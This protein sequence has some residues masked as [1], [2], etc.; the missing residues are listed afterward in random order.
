MGRTVRTV[1]TVM[2]IGVV[3]AVAL[4]VL[5]LGSSTGLVFGGQTTLTGDATAKTP[6]YAQLGWLKNTSPWPLT[7]KSITV[8]ATNASKPTTVYIEPRHVG[9]LSVTPGKTPVW[10]TN[11]GAPPQD[12]VGG[13]LR[14]LAFGLTPTEGEVASFTSIT[15]TFSGPLGFTFHKTFD[16][17]QMAAASATLPDGIL[18][19]DP[20]SDSSSLDGY[21]A[22]LRGG[23]Q[24][25]NAKSLAVIMGGGATVA[26]AQ[27]LL[28]AQKNYHT[29]D[30]VAVTP[31]TPGDVTGQRLVF[32]LTDPTKNALPPIKIQWSGF[33]WTI[34]RG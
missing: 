19:T 14:Y 16:G 25:H 30:K 2:F 27:A 10:A 24:S 9:S 23:L 20:R 15:V 31:S 29:I 21:I 7:I 22:L 4:A 28:V 34:V 5:Y 1:V 18:A 17:I 11:A 32:Y 26:D 3:V 12:L 33:R 6:Y 13:S 8:N